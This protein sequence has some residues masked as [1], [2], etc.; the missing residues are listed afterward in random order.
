MSQIKKT[1]SRWVKS[2]VEVSQ[3]LCPGESNQENP[4]QVK[5]ENSV[6]VSQIK[7]T[8]SRWVKSLKP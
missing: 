3:I 6:Q 1:L 5:Q 7:E 8:L 4:V 2:G